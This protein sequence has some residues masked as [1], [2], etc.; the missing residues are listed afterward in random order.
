MDYS[1][2][3]LPAVLLIPLPCA[4]LLVLLYS[5]ISC[6][7]QVSNCDDIWSMGIMSMNII[8]FILRTSVVQWFDGQTRKWETKS[9]ILATK[10]TR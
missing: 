3:A 8:M 5:T 9:P 6:P 10:L 4:C 1:E 2:M 7:Y